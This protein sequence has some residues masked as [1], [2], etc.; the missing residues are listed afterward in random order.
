M[1]QYYPSMY[2][3][4]LVL[5]IIVIS[6]SVLAAPPGW[7][8]SG[9]SKEIATGIAEKSNI[10]NQSTKTPLLTAETEQ[11]TNVTST[12]EKKGID[13]G[14][15]S[16]AIG[17]TG[18]LIGWY[19]SRK[20]R[21]KS[22]AYLNEIDAVHK[23]FKTK[24]EKLDEAL[25]KLHRTIQS[26][27]ERGKLTDQS[28]ALLDARIEKY[29][30]EARV[31]TISNTFKLPKNIKRQI[32]QMLNDGV[33]TEEEYDQFIDMDITKLSQKEYERLTKLMRKWK[34]MK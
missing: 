18:A 3:L 7:A 29:E 25:T 11:A 6:G 28:L 23:K 34:E 30:K 13:W 17:L 10:D 1:R 20:T 33:I 32:K 27:F 9:K 21:S 22:A 5:L 26:D 24:P 8:K 12:V 31:D 15:I 4:F 2:S 14:A 19:L 16:V